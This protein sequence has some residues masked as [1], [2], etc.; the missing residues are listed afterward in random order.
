MPVQGGE[1]KGLWLSRYGNSHWAPFY[2]ISSL[3]KADYI[4]VLQISGTA[5]TGK[6]AA[7]CLQVIYKPGC[8]TQLSL[9]RQQIMCLDAAARQAQHALPAL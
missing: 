6:D 9:I 2:G 4:D 1:G 5:V 8:M 7:I 3:S